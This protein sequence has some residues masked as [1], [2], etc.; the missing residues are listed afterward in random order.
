MLTKLI[1]GLAALAT[2]PLL[3]AC[4]TLTGVGKD[5]GRKV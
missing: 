3:S 1:Y 5:I 4:N 2:V